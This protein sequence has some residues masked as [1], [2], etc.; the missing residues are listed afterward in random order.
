M[1]DSMKLLIREYTKEHIKKQIDL[2]WEKA[3]FPKTDY[4]DK[5]LIYT[6]DEKFQNSP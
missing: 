5:R 2:K 1:Y 6:T 3:V 4:T